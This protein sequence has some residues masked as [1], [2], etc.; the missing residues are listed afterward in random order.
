M[1]SDKKRT[2]SRSNIGYVGPDGVKPYGWN[3]NPWTWAISF[4][5]IDHA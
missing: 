2:L 4:E 5:V 3:A 1:A